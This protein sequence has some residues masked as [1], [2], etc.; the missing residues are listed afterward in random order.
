[1]RVYAD[2]SPPQ[3]AIKP[4]PTRAPL[5]K[6]GSTDDL[7]SITN[8]GPANLIDLTGLD[9]SIEEEEGDFE[10]IFLEAAPCSICKK[11]FPFADDIYNLHVQTC[12][13]Q[14]VLL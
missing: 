6:G 5:V 9:D 13:R 7:N 10:E 4:A 1:M 11:T 3:W 8:I 14:G 2:A 12:R